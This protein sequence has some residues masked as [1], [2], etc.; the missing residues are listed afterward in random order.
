[1][2]KPIQ[3]TFDGTNYLLWA[4]EMHSFLK[5]R[6]L[7]RYV[8]G[9]F[10][11]PIKLDNESD[12]EFN[13]RFEDWDCINHQILTW[14]RNTIIS[15]IKRLFGRVDNAKDVWDFLERRYCMK[16]R[17]LGFKIFVDLAHTRQQPGQSIHDFLSKIQP[18]WDQ[19]SFCVPSWRCAA[20]S[21]DFSKIKEDFQVYFL[22]MALTDEFDS[23]RDSL[24]HRMPPPSL[25]DV[26]ISELLAEETRLA[27]MKS[28]HNIVSI[29]SMVAAIASSLVSVGSSSSTNSSMSNTG[30]SKKKICRY[31]RSMVMLSLSASVCNQNRLPSQVSQLPKILKDL[32]RSLLL[33]PLRSLVP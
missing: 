28:Q 5:G 16:G 30:S 32:V 22:C 7:W 20:D 10:A 13:D 18:M 33:L 24:L 6:K 3:T 4:D 2:F 21:E 14:F 25:L 27:S 15:D 19:L 26:V 8:S 31:V 12:K 17:S 11:K 29:D 9:D 1:M 23:I